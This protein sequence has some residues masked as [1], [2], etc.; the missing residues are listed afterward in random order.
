MKEQVKRKLPFIIGIVILLVCAVVFGG[1]MLNK[2]A[3]TTVTTPV[4]K[5][6]AISVIKPEVT[7]MTTVIAYKAT[8]EP[9]RYALVSPKVSGKV[10]DVLFENG[11][12][13]S[14]N[15]PLILL[16]DQDIQLQLKSAR[17]GLKSV[18]NQLKIAQIGLAKPKANIETMQKNYDQAKMLFDMGEL[19]QFDLD[20]SATALNLAKQDYESAKL[21]IESLKINIE[22]TKISIEQLNTSLANTIIR[23]PISGVM[24]EK[25]V[26]IGQFVAVGG[27]VLGKVKDVSDVFAVMQVDESDLQYIKVGNMVSV[28][29]SGDEK[30]A[31][32]GTITLIDPSANADSRAF[33]CKVKI[34][35]AEKKLLPG[36]YVMVSANSDM[37]KKVAVIPVKALMG[38]EDGYF[39]YR[40]VNGAAKKTMVT[41]GEIIQNK[42]QIITGISLED[43]VITSNLNQIQGGDAVKVVTGSGE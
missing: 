25:N 17:N 40:V 5:E 19:S 42:V 8:I 16:D 34:N 20:N 39:V 18:Q 4:K 3:K 6:I 1:K 15:D 10:K 36:N 38:T 28:K 41:T 26:E 23:A 24:D 7:E 37:K 12:K 35:N 14:K 13:V 22:T 33:S 32:A 43:Q 27:P 29:L 11:K 2:P 30:M 21:S 9:I 31:F